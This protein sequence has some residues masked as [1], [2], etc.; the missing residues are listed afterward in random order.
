MI[1]TVLYYCHFLTVGFVPVIFSCTSY[2]F[3]EVYEVLQHFLIRWL[4]PPGSSSSR[5]TKYPTERCQNREF[6]LHMTK[7]T[8]GE[9]LQWS[10]KLTNY[11]P[12]LVCRRPAL[13]AAPV[14]SDD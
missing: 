10:P 4:D 13:W 6:C 5:W 3:L 7:S 8:S 11:V 9:V 2:K 12:L 14:M 1:S